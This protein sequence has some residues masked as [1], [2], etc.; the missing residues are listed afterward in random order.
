MSLFLFL[1]GGWVGNDPKAARMLTN[2][3]T[4]MF[5]EF[6]NKVKVNLMEALMIVDGH[7]G[8]VFCR[9]GAMKEV[10]YESDRPF[11][12]LAKEMR[13]NIEIMVKSI[14]QIAPMFLLMKGH[15]KLL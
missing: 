14:A 12:I 8:K 13:S 6:W 7:V 2:W 10:F 11:I 1:E 3:L 5:S 4:W 15:F 9:T